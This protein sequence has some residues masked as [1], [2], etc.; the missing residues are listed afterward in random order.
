MNSSYDYLGYDDIW[1]DI[2]NE[3]NGNNEYFY[4]TGSDKIYYYG[5]IPVVTN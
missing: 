3:Q 2:Y 5:P 1:F 4:Y